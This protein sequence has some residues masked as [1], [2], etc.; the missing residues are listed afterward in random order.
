MS[1]FVGDLFQDGLDAFDETDPTTRLLSDQIRSSTPKRRVK[2]KFPVLMRWAAP[3]TGIAMCPIS[4]ALEERR[5]SACG[6][7]RTP[8]PC[9]Q[10]VRFA[11]NRCYEAEGSGLMLLRLFHRR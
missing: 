7:K 4:T 2:R 6:Y 10:Y 8:R 11:P 9:R 3:T 1:K 5:E